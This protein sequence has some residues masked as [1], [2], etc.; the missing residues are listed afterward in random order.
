MRSNNQWYFKLARHIGSRMIDLQPDSMVMDQLNL[1]MPTKFQKNFSNPKTPL[2]IQKTSF[3]T[4][5]YLQVDKIRINK[6]TYFFIFAFY[7]NQ[8]SLDILAS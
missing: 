7:C 6:I 2:Q 5:N 4:R 8:G 1:F 3:K